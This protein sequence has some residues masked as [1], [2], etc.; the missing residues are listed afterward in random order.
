ARLPAP[1]FQRCEIQRVLDDLETI[2]RGDVDAGRLAVARPAGPIAFDADPDQL[3]RVLLNLVKN[4]LE[5]TAAGGRVEVSARSDGDSV[6]IVVADDGPGLSSKQ[7]AHL[8][9]P[10]FTTKAAGSGLGLTIVERIVSEH[11]GTVTVAD[12]NPHGTRFA[13]RL[14]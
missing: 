6:E 11:G 3:R 1:R 10:G 2:H 8:F 14:P 13:L 7:R 5:A 12:A 9:E 4:G